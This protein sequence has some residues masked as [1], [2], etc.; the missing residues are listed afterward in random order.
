M[1]LSALALA[2]DASANSSDASLTQLEKVAALSHA[3]PHGRLLGTGRD[4]GSDSAIT[5]RDPGVTAVFATTMSVQ[6]AALYYRKHYPQYT[7][8]ILCCAS[9]TDVSELGQNG[10]ANILINITARQPK[11][12]PYYEI[13]V[14]HSNSLSTT[15]VVVSATGTVNS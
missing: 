13:D 10:I 14:P 7:L 6:Q 15:Y 9:L 4:K 5:G 11:I 8:S 1:G 2:C 12:P 3:P